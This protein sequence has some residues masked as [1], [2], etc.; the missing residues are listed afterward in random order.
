MV[1]SPWPLQKKAFYGRI[2]QLLPEISEIDAR[3]CSRLGDAGFFCITSVSPDGAG[4]SSAD[5]IVVSWKGE[6]LENQLERAVAMRTLANRFLMQALRR[7]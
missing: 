6:V 7:W 3:G 4:S 2:I 1:F 5:P